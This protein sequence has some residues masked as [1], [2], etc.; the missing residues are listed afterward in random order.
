LVTATGKVEIIIVLDGWTKDVVRDER[1]IVLKKSEPVGRRVAINEAA[2]IAKGKYLFHLDA[3]CTMS[4]GWDTKLKCACTGRTVVTCLVKPLDENWKYKKRGGYS[5]VSLSPKLEV[6]WWSGYKLAK[7]CKVAEETMA[8][9]GCAWMIQK[10]YFWELGGCD[11]SLGS[12]GHTGSEWSLKVWLHKEFPGRLLIRVDVICGHLFGTNTDNKRY[13]VN[14]A[15]D[16]VFYHW[17]IHNFGDVLPTLVNRLLFRYRCYWGG[18]NSEL[19]NCRRRK[20]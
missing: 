19:H 13:Q 20:S 18:N 11:E 2:R 9:T 10:D 16:S 7:D 4:E 3:H 5:F 1:V 14:M 6:K 12:Y 17:A 8:F 15:S